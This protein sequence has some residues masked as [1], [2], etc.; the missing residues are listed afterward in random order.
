M[1][2]N[3]VMV[4]LRLIYYCFFFFFSFSE[5]QCQKKKKKSYIFYYH[6]YYSFFKS[7]HTNMNTLAVGVRFLDLDTQFVDV[8]PQTRVED[9]KKEVCNEMMAKI[10]YFIV[11][12][13]GNELQDRLLLCDE[14]IDENTVLEIELSRQGIGIQLIGR[15]TT[16]QEL[17][18]LVSEED[19]CEELNSIQSFI[20]A[21]NLN[22]NQ[23]S[24]GFA[25]IHYAVQRN[26]L[27]AINVLSTVR[28]F[29]I[30]KQGDDYITP[31]CVACR[32]GNID[33][34]KAILS[35]KG[36]SVS[37]SNSYGMFWLLHNYY[38]LTIKT[39]LTKKKKKKQTGHPYTL[40]VK[41]DTLQS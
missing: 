25:P 11:T 20:D 2:R 17:I 5:N 8:S 22:V 41:W 21:G 4:L 40:R 29:D 6:L 35:I 13:S 23:L 1:I 14:G 12:L 16:Q 18:K 32:S 3:E 30:N 24:A 28:D 31:L 36:V 27:H 34:V 26:H 9:I 37:T 19:N 10:S 7:V 38:D 33:T 39:K 15:E